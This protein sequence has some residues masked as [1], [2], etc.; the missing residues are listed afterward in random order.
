M[1]PGGQLVPVPGAGMGQVSYRMWYTGSANF[2]YRIG[3]A[4]GR[5]VEFDNHVLLPLVSRN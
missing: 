5:L 4:Q 3:L 2:I 1:L